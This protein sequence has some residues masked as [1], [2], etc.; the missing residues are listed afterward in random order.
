M[1]A[2]LPALIARH[3]ANHPDAP[4]L[5]WHGDT[6]GYGEL[7]AMA[8][9][10]AAWIGTHRGGSGAPRPG[11]LGERP[12]PLALVAKKSPEAVAVVLACLL[13][14][15]PLLIASTDLGAEALSA[16]LASAG[17]ERLPDPTELTARPDEGAP[18]VPTTPYPA[19]DDPDDTA[20]LLTTS[21]STGIPKIAPVTFGALD[22]FTA[23]AAGHF[24]LDA[25][26]TVLNHA[27]LN[28][29]LC[30]FDLWTTLGS[31]GCV[32][33]VD[34]DLAVNPAHLEGILR[35][36]PVHVV[37]GV[38]LLHALLTRGAAGGDA[39]HLAPVRHVLITGD[40]ISGPAFAALPPLFPRARFHNVY[41]C[42]ETND[43]FV[44]EIDPRD[45][46]PHGALPLGSP[47]A[48]TTAWIRTEDGGV[49]HGPGR[50]E[51]V[52][53][54]PFQ[55]PG[56]MGAAPAV[57]PFVPHPEDP[58][59]GPCYRTGDL[60]R[61]HPDGT[62]TLEG[63]RDFVVKVRGV[64]VNTAE[65]EAALCAHDG[66]EEAAVLAVPDD[67]A[68]KVLH[69]VVRRTPAATLDS[70]TLRH[71]LGQRLPRAALPRTVRWS[72]EPLPRT[73]TGKLDRTALTDA[74]ATGPSASGAPGAP[75]AVGALAARA[76][77]DTRPSQ[78]TGD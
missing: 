41:G 34:Q 65:V 62:L 36:R 13:L 35:A 44:H 73:S 10:A 48:G 72:G 51:L 16:L 69:A 21:G 52:V 67:E 75:A 7:V 23:W 76:S 60:V 6:T 17:A 49:L 20:L 15:R 43:S 24:G 70:L 50:G 64:R 37:Q 26:T 59:G 38:P 40:A 27:P 22:R 1:P 58:A 4:A 45:P 63:R 32:A 47:V 12:G 71:Y 46:M 78:G 31:G 55:T 68:G 14:R 29:D 11:D 18:P 33:L 77:A 54:T 53:R 5:F 2:C 39:S 19:A 28:F 66:I 3:A 74:L 57:S 56:Y 9:R 42:T 30:L 8:D 25:E 61:R